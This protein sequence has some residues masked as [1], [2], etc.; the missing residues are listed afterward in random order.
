MGPRKT[1]QGT[2]RQVFLSCPKPPFRIT[3]M[4]SYVGFMGI[5]D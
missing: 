3:I 4:V 5:L 1:V 2:E